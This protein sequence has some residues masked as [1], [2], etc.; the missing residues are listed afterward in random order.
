MLPFL[1]IVILLIG[2]SNCKVDF[3]EENQLPIVEP[4][5]FTKE[6]SVWEYSVDS[7]FKSLHCCARGY[8]SIEW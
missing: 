6:L 1:F 2:T 4:L 7:K 8:L 5:Q 3:C